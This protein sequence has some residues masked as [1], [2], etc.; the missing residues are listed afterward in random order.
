MQ[1]ILKIFIGERAPVPEKSGKAS[2][3][4]LVLKE[5]KA[6]DCMRK[7]GEA[8]QVG[9]VICAKLVS[10]RKLVMSEGW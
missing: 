7:V 8:I 2:K 10:G 3:R 9:A 6:K 4:E 1:E 5:G